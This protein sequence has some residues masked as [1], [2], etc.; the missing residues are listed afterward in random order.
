MK[1]LLYYIGILIVF[2]SHIYILF[3]NPIGST[4]ATPSVIHAYLNLTAGVLIA[5]WFMT[6]K[7]ECRAF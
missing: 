3:K 2:V 5:I 4:L 7:P 6:I 1:V